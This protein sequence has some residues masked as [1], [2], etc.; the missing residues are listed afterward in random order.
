MHHSMKNKIN[1]TTCR[2]KV[3]LPLQIS[4]MIG[5]LGNLLYATCGAMVTISPTAALWSVVVGRVLS[6][7]GAGELRWQ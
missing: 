2:G 1:S 4:L 7:A 6:G 5:I 3:T